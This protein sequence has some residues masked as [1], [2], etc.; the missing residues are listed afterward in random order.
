[1]KRVF[2]VFFILVVQSAA[3]L[4]AV[5][6]PS[7]WPPH[8]A[9]DWAK[10]SG[11]LVGCN[12]I[13]SN[14]ENDLEMWQADTFDPVTIDRELGWAQGLGFIRLERRGSGS[15]DEGYKA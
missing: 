3:L 12:F 11:W 6:E 14:A 13:P 7:Q 4:R 15:F 2:I 9:D 10:Q 5:A 1:M 8:A